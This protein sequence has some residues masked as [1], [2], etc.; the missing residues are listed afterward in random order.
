MAT[1]S[2]NAGSRK[3]FDDAWCNRLTDVERETISDGRSL[4]KAAAGIIARVAGDLAEACRNF[5]PQE[6]IAF[7]LSATAH[8]ARLS[9]KTFD[10]IMREAT[11]ELPGFDYEEVLPKRGAEPKRSARDELPEDDDDEPEDDDDEPGDD[12][13]D[14][15]DE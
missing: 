8:E 4:G 13:D 6:F 5:G 15:D 1:V 14:G 3:P 2:N 12:G 7:L 10:Q 9:A 11:R